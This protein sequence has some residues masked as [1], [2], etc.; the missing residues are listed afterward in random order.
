VSIFISIA[1]YR[2][3]VLIQTIESAIS[4]AKYPKDLYFG[5]VIQDIKR[6]RPDLSKYKNMSVIEM[7]PRDAMGAG[8]AR[9]KAIS[10]FNN[11]DYFLQID[12]HTLFEKDWDEIAIKELQKAKDIS[13][14]NKIILSYFPPPFHIESGKHVSIVKSDKKQLP[15]PTTQRPVVNKRQEWTAERNEFKDKDRKIPELSSTVLGGFI[16]SDSQLIKEVPYDPDISFFGEEI[17]FAMRAWTRGWDIYSPSKIVVYHFYFR[18]EYKKIWKDKN[19]R[20]IS[21]AEI[22]E[23]SKE[24]QK[25]VLCGIEYGIYGAGSDRSLEDFEKFVGINFKKH[26]ELT[27]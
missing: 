22:E 3:P 24:K 16:F 13:G 11:Q 5:V 15:Y 1:S 25:R 6:E 19:I 9:D 18:G 27:K 17:C 10:L 26:Y 12:S 14:N 21:W 20:K 8:F 23:K 7:H 2:D 4:N